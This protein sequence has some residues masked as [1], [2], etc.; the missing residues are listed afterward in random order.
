MESFD[1]LEQYTPLNKKQI[2]FLKSYPRPFT[3]I[4]DCSF[5]SMLIGLDQ[6]DMSYFN[7]EVYKKF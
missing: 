2:H 4:T 1:W 5:L 3:I 7:K 6:E